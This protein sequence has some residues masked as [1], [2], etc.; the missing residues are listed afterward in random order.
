MSASCHGHRPAPARTPK[1]LRSRP[2]GFAAPQRGV[3]LLFGMIALVVLLIGTTALVRSMNTSMMTA[4]NFG[5]K[6]DLTNQ[7]ER[8]IQAVLT[9]LQTGGLAN[10]G[11]REANQLNLNYSASLLPSNAQGIPVALLTDSGFTAV[12][13]T[14]NDITVADMGITVRYVVDRISTAAGPADTDNTLMADNT[15]PAGGS[16]SELMN[17]MDSSSG[18][19]GALAPQVVYRISVRVTGPRNT[20]SF[21]QSTLKL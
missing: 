18:G 14:N 7:G 20:Q 2:A 13:V 15:V 9:A 11:T 5:F 17:A 19:Q 3:V 12:G 1:R 21:Y 4:G 6:R 10:A 8:A 16:S